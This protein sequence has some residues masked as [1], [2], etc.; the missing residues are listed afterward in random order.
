M[1]FYVESEIGLY[2]GIGSYNGKCIGTIS[3][4]GACEPEPERI[5]R[6]WKEQF[7]AFRDR[8][9]EEKES[10]QVVVLSPTYLKFYS[11]NLSE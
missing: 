11:S 1:E 6:H 5:V 10:Q 8:V 7:E 9:L 3:V 4:D 2:F